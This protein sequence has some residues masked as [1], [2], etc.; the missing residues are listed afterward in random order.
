MPRKLNPKYLIL[1]TSFVFLFSS[2]A[3][4]SDSLRSSQDDAGLSRI[5][6]NERGF[7]S[8]E[9]K[10]QATDVLKITVHEHPDLDTIPGSQ[11]TD[12]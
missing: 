12:I 4:N 2:C 5:K 6:L 10:L 8:A 7:K 1:F 3:Q 11:R 9:Y